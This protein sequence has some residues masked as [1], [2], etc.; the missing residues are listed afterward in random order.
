MQR[1]AHTRSV[2]FTL[3][4]LMVVIAIIAILAALL[5]P[6]FLRA[7][8]RGNVGKAITELHQI[9]VALQLYADDNDGAFPPAR[10]FCAGAMG[11]IDD[12]NELPPE[13]HRM[14]YLP[15]RLNDPFNPGRAY[16]YL[17]PGPGYA[18]GARTILAIWLSANYPE[19]SNQMVPYFN[20]NSAPVKWAVWS[21]G[22]G[23]A[24]SIFENDSRM[25]P[26]NEAWW[27]PKRPDGVIVRLSDGRISR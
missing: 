18:N 26:T 12:Y 19:P 10:T 5:F 9:G 11:Q 13:L 3:L 16:K 7:R 25:L 4:E 15:K 20:Q 23:T 17:A 22:P 6:V 8:E 2:G 14:G 21:V 27:Y 1:H 24:P